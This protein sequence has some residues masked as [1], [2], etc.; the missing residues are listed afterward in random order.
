MHL[1]KSVTAV[2]NLS[3]GNIHLPKLPKRVGLTHTSAVAEL[4][5]GG[6]V[7]ARVP[8]TLDIQLDD[9]ASHYLL[10]RGAPLNLVIDTG[11]TRVSAAALLLAPG[12]VGDIVSCQVAR[13]RKVLRAKITSSREATVVQQ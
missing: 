3:V 5:V 12:D 10:E 13:T 11:L 6:E 9:Q 2:P 7:I 8:I 4:G 1:P